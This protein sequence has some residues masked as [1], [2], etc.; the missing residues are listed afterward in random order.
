MV[1]R[2]NNAFE[3]WKKG[4]RKDPLKLSR[5]VTNVDKYDK[6]DFARILKEMK[7][8]AIYR[9]RLVDGGAGDLGFDV[10]QDAYSSFWKVDPEIL[11]RGQVRPSHIVNRAVMQEAVELPDYIE[12]RNWCVAPE[13][14]VLTADLQWI[15]VGDL[16]VGQPLLAFDE[17]PF[18]KDGAKPYAR[19]WRRSLVT[20]TSRVEM[21]CY[22]I[23]FADG[24]I[25][26]ASENHKW[27]GGYGRSDTEQTGGKLQWIATE[28]L[29]AFP[30]SGHKHTQIAKVVETW[31]SE[32]TWELAA[33]F[34]GTMNPLDRIKIVKKEFVGMQT[35]VALATSTK[36]LI[37]EG[38]ASHNTQ[39]DDIGSALAVNSIE[40]D[41][42]DLYKT[43]EE[44]TKQANALDQLLSQLAG[45]EGEK[46]DL[47]ELFDEWTA[48]E[49]PDKEPVDWNE[50]FK[51]AQEKIDQLADQAEKDAKALE[52][53]LDAA[54]SQIKSAVKETIAKAND[55]VE[56]S[57]NMAESWGLEPGE[58]QR[59]PAERRIEL[60][61]KMQSPKFQRIAELFGPMKCLAFS[62]QRRKVN[63]APEEVYDIELGSDLE[64]VLL[65]EKLK[66]RHPT[67]KLLFMKDLVEQR[68]PQYKMRGFE[69]VGKGGII[70][71]MD[72]SG[73]MM[74]EREIWAKA[75]GLCLLRVARKQK[76]PF[77]AINFSGPR[78]MHC[79]DFSGNSPETEISPDRVIEF[80]EIFYGGG[81]DFV[82]PLT[83]ALELLNREHSAT[84]AL[85]SDIV[86]AT[87]GMCGVS[88]DFMKH[89]EEEQKRLDFK[90]WGINIGG[91]VADEPLA[92]IADGRVASIKSLTSGSSVREVFGGL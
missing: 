55:A 10:Y 82:T 67:L 83:K 44:E 11:T 53:A 50:K 47:D 64:K 23:T 85:K 72:S 29:V 79:M 6:Q 8:F 48:D 24:T 86:F 84:G 46:K 28:D 1:N 73:S 51:E 45:A 19:R 52:E 16:V 42:E 70:Y 13:S 69:K 58:L 27:L 62:E 66:L 56:N 22:D 21:P 35:V 36:T 14:R 78:Q 75:V 39:G 61:K 20:A 59:M 80:A 3:N 91:N 71:C 81:T 40:P 60:S 41:L 63:Y 57:N 68:L 15:P 12:L 54:Q 89:F 65:V 9:Q 18:S 38:F 77:Y 76:R 43:L 88:E 33:A 34:E 74:G 49:D 2:N 90:V 17:E 4:G 32:D 37:V 25:I 7:D 92:R 87:D 26:R 5:H 30:E 31:E